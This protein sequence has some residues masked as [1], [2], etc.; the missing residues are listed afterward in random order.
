MKK[1]SLYWA[2]TVLAVFL[3]VGFTS[4][5]NP[6][7]VIIPFLN[8]SSDSL[9]FDVNGKCKDNKILIESNVDWRA[10]NTT[11]WIK[12]SKIVGNG[13]DTLEVTV[14]DNPKEEERKDYIIVTTGAITKEIIICQ[15]F[16]NFVITPNEL[17]LK[18]EQDAAGEFCISSC[19]SWVISEI[20]EWLELSKE[21]GTGDATITVKAQENTTEEERT[22]VLKVTAGLMEKNVKIT[23]SF[24][25]L[26]VTPSLEINYSK[27]S[28]GKFTIKI[29][30]QWSISGIPEWLK[31]SK[32]TGTG[33]SNVTVTAQ[34]DNIDTQVRTAT[35]IVEAG[36]QKAEVIVEQRPGMTVSFSDQIVLSNGYWCQYTFSSE[37]SGFA[38]VLIPANVFDNSNENETLIQQELVSNG[39]SIKSRTDFTIDGLSAQTEY[40]HCIALYSIKDGVK[41]WGSKILTPR[42]TTASAT[43]SAGVKIGSIAQQWESDKGYFWRFQISPDTT[44]YYMLMYSNSN[45]QNLLSNRPPDI[46]FAAFMY[47]N[48]SDCLTYSAGDLYSKCTAS[49]YL[50]FI[51]AWGGPSYGNITSGYGST[52]SSS[53]VKPSYVAPVQQ[54][55]YKCSNEKH[56]QW[57][58]MFKACRVIKLE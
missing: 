35:L 28:T 55:Y 1:F 45:A 16:D 36:S 19:Q 6:D 14:G 13:K 38:D 57:E 33:N 11:D 52:S 12:C 47:Q 51:V 58:E 43:S 20:P 30:K 10:E 5:N 26:T 15:G 44:P 56:K 4:C 34:S 23:Q 53:Y 29:Q 17:T 21:D 42:F 54:R 50:L 32:E 9:F 24:N 31:L 25:K 7:E 39:I 46:L 37:V 3:S 2:I 48:S 8:M 41:K 22:A 27:N 18:Y 40:V 49:D